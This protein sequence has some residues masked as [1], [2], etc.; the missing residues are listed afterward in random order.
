MKTR[1]LV[2]LATCCIGLI[3]SGIIPL[4]SAKSP[5]DDPGTLAA[6]IELAPLRASVENL[7]AKFP[8]YKDRGV[9]FLARLEVFEKKLTQHRADGDAE[10]LS[11]LIRELQAFRVEVATANP[12]IATHP[13][14]FVARHQYQRDH[15]N[16]ATMFQTGE[17][18]TRKYDPRNAALK[19]IDFSQGGKVTTLFDPGDTGLVRDPEVRYDGKRIIFSMRKSVRDNYHIYEMNADGTG[20]RQ[21]TAAK[22]VFDID[23]LYLP[24]GSIVFTSSR[25]PK[26]CMC[27]RHIMGNMFKMDADGANIHQIGKSTLFEGHSAMLYDGRIIYDRWEYVDRNFG[28]AQGL[29]TVNPDGTNHAIYWGNNTA[30]PGGVIDPRAI[31]GTDR[32]MCIFGSCH[33]RPWGAVAILDRTKGVDGRPAVVRTWPADAI[34]R[35]STT[36]GGKWDAFMR[37]PVKYEDPFPLD[38]DYFLVSRTTG[39][40]EQT[41]IYLIDTF[42]NQTLLHAEPNGCF[43]PMPIKPSPKP[44]VIPTRRDFEN[45]PG[46]FYVQNVYRGTHMA[47]VKPGSIKFLRVIEAPEKRTWTNASWGGQGTIAPSMNWHDFSNKRI[48][49]T[50]PVEE[51]GSAYFEVPSDTFVF[52]QVLDKDGKMIQSMRS[53]TIIQSGETQGCVGCHDNRVKDTPARRNIMAVRRAPSKMNGWYGKPRLFNYL[54]EVQPVFDRHCVSCHDY[55][56]EAGKTLNLAADK[57][58]FFNTSYMELWRKKYIACVG[59][60]PSQIQQAY[61]WG[62]HPSKLIQVLDNGHEGVELTREEMDRLITWVDMNGPYYPTYDSA[63]PRSVTGRSPLDGKQLDKLSKLTGFKFVPN[64]RGNLGPLVSFDRPELSPCLK[65]LDK[66]SPQYAQ[67]LSI[68]QMGQQ[69]LADKPR[70]DMP[71]FQP[72]DYAVKRLEFY[73]QL[74]QR[75]LEVRKAIREGRKIYD[76]GIG[77]ER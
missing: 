67:A 15:H 51:D 48:L 31:P 35:V 18:N 10:R 52:F 40:G 20:L 65:K 50:V 45:G 57:T 28:D 3:T 8:D 56:K 19:T 73:E 4:S 72:D 63:Y 70:A 74:S 54:D 1:A 12:L 24:D 13:I 66:T 37:L 46:R 27:N 76:Q 36:G 47:G 34:N 68:I 11:A 60:G 17:I 26:Y 44:P 49:G 69:S 21:L 75:E 41:G 32:A 6:R 42:G 14:L 29:W 38:E 43:D 9:D 53:G 39:H 7:I 77:P 25:E 16:T 33:D 5:Q 2:V 64:H 55:G 71:G 59:G 22:G 23:P 61:S 58:V 62:S 30:S